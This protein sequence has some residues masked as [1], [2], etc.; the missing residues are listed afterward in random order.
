[1][2][3]SQVTIPIFIPHSGCP[4]MCIFCNQWSATGTEKQADA[5]FINSQVDR[6]L[7]GIPE[8]VKH[9]EIAFFG[10]SFTAIPIKKQE[11]LLEAANIHLQRKTIQGIRL[12]TRPDYIDNNIL[13][14]L[15]KYG[16]TTIELGVQSFDDTV[17]H[18][19]NR[20]HT[21]QD[22]HEAIGLIEK[23]GFNII[24]QLM[25]GLPGDTKIK[26]IQSAEIASSLSPSGARIYPA[27]VIKNTGLEKLY[28]DKS[29]SPLSMEEAVE[30]CK[31]M[32]IIFDNK[33]IPVIRI[34]LHPFSGE[35]L[36]NIIAG[37]YHPS[38]GFFVKSRIKRDNT[39]RWILDYI[40]K[41]GV[42]ATLDLAFPE[43]EREE[44]IG[45]KKENIEFFKNEF[46]IKNIN[47]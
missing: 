38:F 42:P 10:G 4:H 30:T 6:Y 27:V 8:S 7:S 24:I 11:E 39:C 34:G 26:S 36:K 20:G 16:V 47:Y 46:G 37:P 3:K 28:L 17:L 21:A 22:S 32:H 18:A 12:S 14:F 15:K 40:K 9:I 41:N 35:E 1:M 2:A 13:G 19:S 33:N 25:P 23:S 5:D 29:Y 45:Y 31:E 44:Y 43:K